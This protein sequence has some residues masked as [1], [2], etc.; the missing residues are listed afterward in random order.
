[1][2]RTDGVLRAQPHGGERI[3]DFVRE[4][5]GHAPDRGE[6][7]GP[8]EIAPEPRAFFARGSQPAIKL[9]KSDHDSIQLALTRRGQ[10]PQFLERG[11][12]NRVLK[13]ADVFG[14]APQETQQPKTAAERERK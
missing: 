1:M 9:V 5:G 3:S 13:P 11:G 2:V 7:V 6:P 12:G 10:R 8:G 4:P 14:P